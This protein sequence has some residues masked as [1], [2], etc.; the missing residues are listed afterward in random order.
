MKNRSGLLSQGMYS[1]KTSIAQVKLKQAPRSELDFERAWQM[2]G[3]CTCRLSP[4][5]VITD[6]GSAAAR[7]HRA[8]SSSLPARTG[9]RKANLR[10]YFSSFL[11]LFFLSDRPVSPSSAFPLSSF[12]FSLCSSFYLFPSFPCI[13]PL[14]LNPQ[15][16]LW[17]ITGYMKMKSLYINISQSFQCLKKTSPMVMSEICP[18]L[19]KG[20]SE[21]KWS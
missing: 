7:S 2:K 16:Q 9:Q 19:L 3:A 18:F 4:P 14:S 12:F 1:L 11:P 6:Q 17:S 13:M 20:C 5:D 10:P 15:P 21:S 8:G